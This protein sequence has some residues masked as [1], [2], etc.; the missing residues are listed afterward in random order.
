MQHG[1]VCGSHDSKGKDSQG[2]QSTLILAALLHKV[3]VFLRDMLGIEDDKANLEVIG[4]AVAL[5]PTVP[6]DNSMQ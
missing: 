1:I 2:F 5:K 3:S 4:L 6:S